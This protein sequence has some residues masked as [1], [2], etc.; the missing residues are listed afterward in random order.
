MTTVLI[1]IQWAFPLTRLGLQSCAQCMLSS[2]PLDK[3]NVNTVS[4]L[5]CSARDKIHELITV[6][7]RLVQPVNG[8]LVVY[9][10]F[11]C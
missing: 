8:G 11:L 6:L 4:K 7:C 2:F 5:G 10:L 1:H 9:N 3:A